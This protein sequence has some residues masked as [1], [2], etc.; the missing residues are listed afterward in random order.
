MNSV[1]L[2]DDTISGFTRS[3][4]V[5]GAAGGGADTVHGQNGSGLIFGGA[6]NDSVLDGAGNELGSGLDCRTCSQ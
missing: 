3:D 5:D 2:G 6:D 4:H 1:N